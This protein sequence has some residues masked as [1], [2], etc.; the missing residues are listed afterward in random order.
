MVG[1]QKSAIGR[2]IFGKF[3]TEPLKGGEQ[4]RRTLMQAYRKP[5]FGN[6][7]RAAFTVTMY[8]LLE[9]VV[10]YG[11][12]KAK[13][14]LFGPPKNPKSAPGLADEERKANLSMLPIAGPM[15]ESEI[16]RIKFPNSPQY[17]A[18]EGVAMMPLNTIISI[19]KSIDPELTDKQR[20]TASKQVWRDL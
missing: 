19:T 16:D 17:G 9:G 15:I 14:L 7:S 1:L 5:T 10:F 18:T 3:Q 4:I 20:Q 13:E 11:L 6:I 12:D 2:N 8:G